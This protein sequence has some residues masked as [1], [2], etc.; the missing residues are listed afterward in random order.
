MYK[1][2]DHSSLDPLGNF[3]RYAM[4]KG[5]RLPGSHHENYRVALTE[6]LAASLGLDLG[7]QVMLR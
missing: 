2:S 7:V 6:E 4:V 5:I 3:V 1:V